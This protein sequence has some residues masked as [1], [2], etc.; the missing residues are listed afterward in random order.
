[1][2][3]VRETNRA[4]S[5]DLSYTDTWELLG[6]GGRGSAWED[7]SFQTQ[8]D[9]IQVLVLLPSSCMTLGIERQCLSQHQFPELKTGSKSRHGGTYL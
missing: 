6:R 4:Q 3:S 1:M 5:T 7:P 9:L 2:A 8:R